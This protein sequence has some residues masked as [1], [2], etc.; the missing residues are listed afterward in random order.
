MA[1]IRTK[2]AAAL[3]LTKQADAVK[4]MV[5]EGLLTPSDAESVIETINRDMEGIDRKRNKMYQEHGDSSS[6]RR[7]ALRKLQQIPTS[8]L[9]DNEEM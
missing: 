2:Q 8:G 7:K 9:L 1:A 3:M 6:R 4:N 5:Q